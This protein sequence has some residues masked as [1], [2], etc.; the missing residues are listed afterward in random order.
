WAESF[1]GGELKH[2]PLAL[3]EA[4]TPVIVVDPDERRMAVN[5]AEVRT[6][7][8][9]VIGLGGPGSTI[10]V[11][12]TPGLSTTDRVDWLGPLESVVAMQMLAR[13]LAL[14]LG[15]DV[16]KPRNLAKSVTVE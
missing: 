2:G 10:P 13:E 3:V 9:H 15:C 5:V 7:G 6:R 4:H 1:P 8:G 14:S 11:I 12:G 16:D